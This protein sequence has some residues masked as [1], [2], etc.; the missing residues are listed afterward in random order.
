MSIGQFNNA[1]TNYPFNVHHV[2]PIVFRVGIAAISDQ[3]IKRTSSGILTIQFWSVG[4]KLC[5]PFQPS[6]REY[7]QSLRYQNG[8]MSI[9]SAFEKCGK[10]SHPK[11]RYIDRLQ[12]SQIDMYVHIVRQDMGYLEQVPVKISDTFRFRKAFDYLL[13]FSSL[14]I[15]LFVEVYFFLCSICCLFLCLTKS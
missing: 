6:S 11:D 12:I 13:F 2:R 3:S 8:K 5:I 14:G 7:W 9:S 4:S 1:F 15:L 10:N